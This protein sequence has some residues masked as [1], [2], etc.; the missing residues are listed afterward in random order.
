VGLKLNGTH[1]LLVY[2]D[3]VNLLGDKINATKRN[4]QTLIDTSKEVGIEANPEKTNCIL[5][6]R[7]QSA[8]QN[9]DMKRPNRSLENVA[10]RYLGTTVTNQNLIQ[11]EIKK[12]LNSSNACY[13]SVHDLWSS[14]LLPKNI[15]IRICKT[16]ILPGSV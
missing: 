3:D 16:I 13:H 4:T 9:H 7:H 1:Q 10:F 14:R 11:E 15:K 6:S 12:R 8:G 2:A 5:L